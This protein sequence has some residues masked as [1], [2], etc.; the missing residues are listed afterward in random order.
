[1]RF[2]VPLSPV[3][4]ASAIFWLCG[5]NHEWPLSPWEPYTTLPYGKQETFILEKLAYDVLHAFQK[6]SKSG[7]ATPSKE[8]DKIRA[9]LKRAAEEYEKQQQGK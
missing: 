7:T 9:R 5:H 6:K 1:M 2:Q 8:I 4:L 3:R